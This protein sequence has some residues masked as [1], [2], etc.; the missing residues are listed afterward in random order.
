LNLE[1]LEPPSTIDRLAIAGI[2]QGDLIN[3]HFTL[4]LAIRNAFGLHDAD[5]KLLAACG[6]SIETD[7]ASHMIIIQLWNRLQQTI[8]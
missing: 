8:T 7:E 5:S 2:P 3:L 6:H 4:N 1:I